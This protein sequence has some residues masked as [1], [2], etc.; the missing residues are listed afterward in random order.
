MFRQQCEDCKKIWNAAF[1]IVGTTQIASPPSEC[2]YC[3][4]INFGKYADGWEM[5][6]GTIHPDHM[7]DIVKRNSEA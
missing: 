2:P 5:E 6:D 7:K 4:S 3:H 1:G